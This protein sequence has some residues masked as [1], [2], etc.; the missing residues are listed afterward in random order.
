ML[1]WYGL[2]YADFMEGADEE[3]AAPAEVVDK[4]PIPMIAGSVYDGEG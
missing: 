1:T 2:E 4:W 3:L